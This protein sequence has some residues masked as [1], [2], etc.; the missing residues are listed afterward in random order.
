MISARVVEDEKKVIVDVSGYISSKDAKTFLMQYNQSI[1]GIKTSMYRLVVNT[2]IF[3]CENENDIKNVCMAF[4][5][6]NYK[7][8]Y[9][10]DPNNY[11]MSTMSLGTVEKKLFTKSVKIVKSASS[12]K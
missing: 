8:M 7:K 11:I 10:V 5:K 9:L 6:S 2:S 4:Y 3:E 1:K 12:I